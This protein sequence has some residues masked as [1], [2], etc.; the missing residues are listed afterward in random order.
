MR[1]RHLAHG[2]VTMLV[3][4]GIACE[5]PSGPSGDPGDPGDPG[6]PGDDR[7]PYDTGPGLIVTIEDAAISP[8]GTATAIVVLTDADGTPLDRAGRYTEGRV[9]LS[10]VLAYLDRDAQGNA[11]T[12]AAYTT[13]VQTVP[14][15]DASA[16]QAAGENTGT[17]EEL[18]VAQGRYRY[19]FATEIDVASR[20]DTHT[21]GV[22]GSR[23]F[24]GGTYFDDATFDFV[25]AG[26][27]VDYRREITDDAAC[28]RCHHQLAV[29]GGA[30]RSVELC[31]LCHTP[32]TVDP[33]TG[34][35][36]DMRVLI[37]KIHM[38]EDLPSVVAGTPYVVIGHNQSVHDYSTVAF[39]APNSVSHC[40][41]CHTGDHWRTSFSIDTCSSCHD[42]TWFGDPADV[43]AGHTVH[44]G[45]AQPDE[46]CDV[47]HSRDLPSLP[48][49]SVVSAH[50]ID[51]FA[52]DRPE[53]QLSIV[54]VTDTG[55]GEAPTITFTVAVRGQP[56][57]ILAEPLSTLRAT[58]AGPNTDFARYWQS[59]IQGANAGGT[60]RAGG[61]PGE[62][63]WTA[64]ASAA[65]PD[66]A[67][68]S[69][70]VALEAN[71]VNA[72]G[73][74]IPAF[75]PMRA[76]AVTDATPAPR[77]RIIDGG[78]CNDCHENLSFHGGNRA[79]PEYCAMC[80][81]PNNINDE[82]VARLEGEQVY[83]HTVQLTNMVH[84]IHMGEALTQPYVLGGNPAPTEANPI[85]TPEDFSHVRYPAPRDY[86]A[87]CHVGDSHRLASTTAGR[88]PAFDQIFTCNEPAAADDDR[89]C[90]P[91]NP[92]TPAN[93]L[94]VPIETIWLRPQTAA[95]VGCHDA[96]ATYAHALVMTAPT[97]VESCATCHGPGAEFEV[98]GAQ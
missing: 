23:A 67:T 6:G 97:G 50:Q 73:V 53:P 26:G 46:T 4:A 54:S 25:P 20:T 47:C 95:C 70:T 55:P 40:E 21:V 84:R 14:D 90:E 15:G 88:L 85:G 12:Y 87:K 58:F 92:A 33:D 62:F 18:G 57:D 7:D 63:V 78:K 80:H 91:F 60:L 81:N 76:V 66:G 94:F 49:T 83:V 69:Y 11:T 36:M 45:G 98:H 29:H 79:N 5:G 9:N 68:G 2:L 72:N 96:P 64:P 44:G 28:A 10:F 71:I 39:P 17:W 65:I 16:V 3:A 37:H 8:Q 77:R 51:L 24:G 41:S 59:T 1:S 86:C 43:P 74:R 27:A 22:Y 52:P 93:N 31:I 48:P 75:A 30:R 19:T 42:R 35:T 61:A 38:G 34:H 13:R 32:Q 89:L 56:R 82:R